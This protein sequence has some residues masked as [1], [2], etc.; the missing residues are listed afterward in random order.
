MSSSLSDN[1]SIKFGVSCCRPSNILSKFSISPTACLI[2]PS[3]DS[4]RLKSALKWVMFLV[5]SATHTKSSSKAAPK[6]APCTRFPISNAHIS[7]ETRRHWC[8]F[9]KESET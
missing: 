2:K 5:A 6:A 4:K 3:V 8:S 1:R 7:Q 9:Q